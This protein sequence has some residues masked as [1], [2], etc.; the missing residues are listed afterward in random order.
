M[1]ATMRPT[2]FFALV[3]VA[4]FAAQPTTV[5]HAQL[6]RAEHPAR[7]VIRSGEHDSVILERMTPFTV[8][9]VHDTIALLYHEPLPDSIMPAGALVLGVVTIQME[10]SE[11]ITPALEKLARKIG[12]DWIV[13]FTEPRAF[14]ARDRWK[15]YR[16]TAM[17]IRV[18]DPHLIPQAELATAY[19]ET[20]HLT[21]FA[22][23][24]EW[25]DQ[26]GRRLGHLQTEVDT[27]VH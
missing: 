23:V 26:F 4:A 13:S 20:A 15:L 5:V 8:P 12:A 22:S 17:L 3:L 14:L 10:L 21:T 7:E 18:L 27:T 19:Y 1:K 2:P 9:P 25:Y 16:S 11:D 6:F 24:S